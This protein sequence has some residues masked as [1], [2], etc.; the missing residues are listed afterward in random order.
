MGCHARW[1]MGVRWTEPEAESETDAFVAAEA[2]EPTTQDTVEAEDP[3]PPPSWPQTQPAPLRRRRQ[4]VFGTDQ[5]RRVHGKRE[6]GSLKHSDIIDF[7]VCHTCGDDAAGMWSVGHGRAHGRS[8]CPEI[9]RIEYIV[10]RRACKLAGCWPHG[11][12]P[13]S[14]SLPEDSIHA[15]LSG[16]Q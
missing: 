7:G 8:D 14:P 2:E 12:G 15:M 16:A 13:G 4:F 1:R 6:C 11:A 5:G 3:P 10:K 9:G